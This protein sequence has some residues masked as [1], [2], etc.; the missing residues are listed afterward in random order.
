MHK[1]QRD[2]ERT[3][4][5]EKVVTSESV[6][7]ALFLLKQQHFTEPFLMKTGPQRQQ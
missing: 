1:I 4:N 7:V 5:G 6:R 3:M 2:T